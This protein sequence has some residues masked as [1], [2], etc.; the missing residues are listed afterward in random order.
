METSDSYLVVEK[1][2]RGGEIAI[3]ELQD[4]LLALEGQELISVEEHVAL[5]NLAAEMDLDRPAST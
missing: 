4:L 5:L 3:E 2:I 1:M